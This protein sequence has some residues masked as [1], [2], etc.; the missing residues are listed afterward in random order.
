MVLMVTMG[1]RTRLPRPSTFLKCFWASDH[2]PCAAPPLLMAL[3]HG[4][5]CFVHA[6]MSPHGHMTFA[7]G[8]K[9]K[10][11][12]LDIRLDSWLDMASWPSGSTIN[13]TFGVT[14]NIILLV[15]AVA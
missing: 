8:D 9:T 11:G 2:S 10:P 5:T 7:T 14:L 1:A 4:L 3:Q 15:M 6:Y 12:E 13:M